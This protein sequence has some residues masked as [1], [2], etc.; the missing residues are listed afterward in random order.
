MLLETT[1][2]QAWVHT[3]AVVTLTNGEPSAASSSISSYEAAPAYPVLTGIND[4]VAL[5][6]SVGRVGPI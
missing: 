5:S 2:D 6:D 3:I 1:L 4:R